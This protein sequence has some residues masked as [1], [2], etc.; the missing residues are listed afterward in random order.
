MS[1]VRPA[2]PP[3]VA[4]RP[5]PA[6][7]GG[8]S[9][10]RRPHGLR[11]TVSRERSGLGNPANG[12]APRPAGACRILMI[13][14]IIG[15]PGGSRSSSALPGIRDERG[16]DFVTA[17]GE[18]VAGGMG[19]TPSTAEALF[20]AGVDVITSGN[21]IWDKREIYPYPR[22]ATNG[23]CG[24]STTAPTSVPGRGW[25]M[26]H[27]LDGT[28]L[29]VIN[30]QGRTYM[31]QIENPFTDAD[32]LLDEAS[33]P[34][35]PIRLV[36]F[37]CEITSEKNA[38]GL[39]LDGRVSVVVGTHTHV[40]TGD[41]RI[42]PKGTAYQTDLGMTGPAVERHRLRPEDRPAALHQRAADAVRGGRGPGRPQ[43]L[44]GRRRPGHRPGARRS[45]GS[46]G[47]SRSEAVTATPG[48]RARAACRRR[49]AVPPGDATARRP[50]PHDPL[51]RRP[52]ARRARAPG[53]RAPACGC[54]RSPTTTTSRATASSSRRRGAV[55]AGLELVPGVEIN[56]V[57]RGLGLE[58]AGGELHVLGLAWIRTTTAFEAALAG[59]RAAAPRP[60]RRHARAP[61]RLGHRRRRPGRGARPHRDDA[62]GRPTV[63]R[64]LIAAGYAESVEDAFEPAPRLRHAGLRPA[65]G[66]RAGRGDPARSGRPAGSPRSRT[67]REAPDR[68]SLMRD[69][70]DEGLN[71]LE[72]HHRSFDAGPR[73][74]WARSPGRWGWW[75][76]AAPTT[77][78]TTGRTRRRHAGLVMPDELSRGS[79]PRSAA[80]RDGA[81]VPSA[82]TMHPTRRRPCPA[83][84]RP[85]A[86]GRRPA[87]PRDAARARR[88][89]P[90]RVPA[91]GALAAAVLRLDA[92]LP[93]EQE[94]L[95]GDGRAAARRRLRRGAR[96][97]RGRPRRHQHLR[98]PRGGRGE[99][100]R[101]P[102][103]PQPA[104]GREPRR[105]GS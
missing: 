104:E 35:P 2:A 19:L 22:V 75:R 16:I 21:H 40:V 45:S 6:R 90:R 4:R 5:L 31:Q 93:D 92:R 80:E 50:R 105:C 101:P 11:T 1:R 47:S 49:R 3:G 17:N 38:L 81:G 57:T 55:P 61:A 28:E 46:S 26:Y 20:E 36:D 23:C 62:L 85:R 9:R 86:A 82:A 77:T 27:A 72:T 43:R 52:R 51:R 97:G 39:Y 14:D 18:N 79:G 60:L 41:E 54:S 7:R 32:R 58:I 73:A 89:A 33:E 98:D 12:N 70:V 30:L 94:R 44:P 95:R 15:K 8:D 56:A 103:P 99:G 29:A 34:L 13:G 76:P 88:R 65:P 100:H 53:V 63:A 37:H 87:G 84:P 48:P 66:P 25:G 42:L 96:D 102:G 24:R 91:R 71:G 83:R 74:R 10:V 69:L 64:A 67:S 59:Q 68:S 78:A